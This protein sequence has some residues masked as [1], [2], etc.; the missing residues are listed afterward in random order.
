MD[1]LYIGTDEVCPICGGRI[2]HPYTGHVTTEQIVEDSRCCTWIE[3][4]DEGG[5]TIGY[6]PIC[7]NSA[8][9]M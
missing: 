7:K 4:V 3:V 1:N 5:G 9:F 2:K 6:R 8:L